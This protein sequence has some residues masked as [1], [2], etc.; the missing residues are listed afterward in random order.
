MVPQF[1]GSGLQHLISFSNSRGSC[2]SVGSKGPR[3]KA[4][5]HH[6]SSYIYNINNYSI[7]K[8]MYECKCSLMYSVLPN[9]SKCA[10]AKVSRKRVKCTFRARACQGE[11]DDMDNG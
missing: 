9:V 3:P 6:K 10:I 7:Q 11:T 4:G 5:E 1:L 2:P 8:C